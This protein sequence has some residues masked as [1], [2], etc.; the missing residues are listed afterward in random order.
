MIVYFSGTGNSRYAAA[1][2]ADRLGDE[3]LDAGTLIKE[4]KKAE[5]T[6]EK[7]WV[8]VAPTYA[9]QLPRVFSDLLRNG[10]FEGS[11]DAY[12]VMTCGADIGSPEKEL[13]A[14]CQVKGFAFRGVLEVVMPENYIT[15]FDAPG[16]EEAARIIAAARPVLEEGARLIGGGESFPERSTG[17][18]DK[19]KSGLINEMFY[20]VFVKAKAFH[21]TKDCNGCGLCE[22]LC[23]LNNIELEGKEPL[24]GSRCTQCMACICGCP[25]EAIEYGRRSKGKVRYQCQ[26]YQ[27]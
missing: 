18:A 22:K 7:P 14:L 16:Q 13:S 11:K 19:L 25:R 1:L 3:I 15:L 5:L 24:W 23:P 21:V 17:F 4:K 26:E 2:L 27:G 9:W 6:S 10:L 8:F 20:P 12:F